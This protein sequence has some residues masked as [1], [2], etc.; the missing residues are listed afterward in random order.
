M[1][2]DFI[3]TI[4]FGKSANYETPH[5]LIFSIV[6]LFPLSYINTLHITLFPSTLDLSFPEVGKILVPCDAEYE[7]DYLLGCFAM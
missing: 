1:M 2:F 4:K 6:R 7:D 3:T 5:D